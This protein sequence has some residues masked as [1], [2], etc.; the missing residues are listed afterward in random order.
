MSST[1]EGSDSDIGSRIQSVRTQS[2]LSQVD[3][4]ARLGISLRAFQN[5]ERGE[6]PVSKQLLCALKEQFNVDAD[7][8]L[9]DQNVTGATGHTKPLGQLKVWGDT[10]QMADLLHFIFQE[11]DKELSLQ[12]QIPNEEPFWFL[13]SVYKDV[14]NHLPD[15]VPVNSDDAYELAKH[16]VEEEVA[17]YNR[18]LSIAHKNTKEREQEVSQRDGNS[19]TKTTQSFHGNVSQVGGGDINNN[20][21]KKD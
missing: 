9:F 8:I 13:A 18:M 3:F 12:E 2:N 7:Y 4:A 20:F 6:R 5:Y 15:G 17:H 19:E 21:G 10:A 14:M 16:F 11:L 1:I